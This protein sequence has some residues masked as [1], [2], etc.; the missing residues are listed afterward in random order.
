MI[1]RTKTKLVIAVVSSLVTV[2]TEQTIEA[3][4]K[5]LKEKTSRKADK[6]AK[7]S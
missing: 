1:T 2:V 5:A 6:H 3:V 7:R 4:A